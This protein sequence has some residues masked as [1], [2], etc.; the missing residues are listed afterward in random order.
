M[1]VKIIFMLKIYG[2]MVS[3]FIEI[4]CKNKCY[5]YSHTVVFDDNT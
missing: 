4:C 2:L 5:R 3:G 1:A